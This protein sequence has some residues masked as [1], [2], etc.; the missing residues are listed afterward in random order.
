M[1]RKIPH[2]E[3]AASVIAALGGV[4]FLAKAVGTTTTTVQRW[5]WPKEVGGTG[6]IIPHWHH[7]AI[8]ALAERLGV[9]LS[10][11]ALMRPPGRRA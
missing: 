1:R 3:P 5:R 9:P 10:F 11:E 8:L 4:P 2:L 6:G 7:E